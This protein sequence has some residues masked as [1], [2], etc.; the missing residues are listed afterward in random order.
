MV[1]K[2]AYQIWVSRKYTI[3]TGAQMA[4]IAPA[5][6]LPA[7]AR[8]KAFER[9]YQQQ[10]SWA[11]KMAFMGGG[12]PISTAHLAGDRCMCIKFKCNNFRPFSK[13]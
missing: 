10:T 1:E 7:N 3:T 12:Y 2:M 5:L 11:S 4:R 8:R 13:L 9:S 6:W